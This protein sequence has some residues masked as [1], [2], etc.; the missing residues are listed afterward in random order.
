MENMARLYINNVPPDVHRVLQRRALEA[1]QSL[2]EYVL[3]LLDEHVRVPTL[4][5]VLEHAAKS[6]VG[7]LPLAE[8]ANQRAGSATRASRGKGPSRGGDR[9]R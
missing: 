2:E 6:P 9:P 1:G 7:S 5:E 3:A 8:A 4:E